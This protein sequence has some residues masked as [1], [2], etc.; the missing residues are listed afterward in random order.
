MEYKIA[1]AAAALGID[2]HELL[3]LLYTMTQEGLAN[4]RQCE[5]RVQIADYPLIQLLAHGLKGAA[6]NLGMTRFGTLAADLEIAAKNSDGRLIR[7]LL[8]VLKRELIEIST[9]LGFYS[10]Q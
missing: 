7:E 10:N 9:Q 8:P 4:I 5:S 2:D 1:E 3:P 6:L